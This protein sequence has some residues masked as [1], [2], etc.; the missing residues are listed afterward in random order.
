MPEERATINSPGEAAALVQYEMSVLEQEH[1]RV[2]LLDTRN[3]V[4]DIVEGLLRLG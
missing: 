4:L 3:D 1:L 2:L